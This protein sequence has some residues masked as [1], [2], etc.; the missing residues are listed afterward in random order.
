MAKREKVVLGY[1]V[2]LV[3]GRYLGPGGSVVSD[4]RCAHVFNSYRIACRNV[5]AAVDGARVLRRVR[6]VPSN[7]V[8]AERERC[9]EVCRRVGTELE[10]GCYDQGALDVADECARRILEGES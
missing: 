9:A 2:K 7:A 1:V 10:N 5:A 4:K 8:L 6:S 3:D